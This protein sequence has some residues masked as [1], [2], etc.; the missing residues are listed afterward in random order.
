VTAA[1]VVAIIIEMAVRADARRMRPSLRKPGARFLMSA[2]DRDYGWSPEFI[3][4]Y[5]VEIGPVNILVCAGTWKLSPRQKIP[6]PTKNITVVS[7]SIAS[8]S[9]C[10]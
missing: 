8:R 2:H 7:E 1:I 10:L 6:N 5:I 9:L 3:E 4:C